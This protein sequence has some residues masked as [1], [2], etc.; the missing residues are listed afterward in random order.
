MVFGVD[1]HAVDIAVLRFGCHPC[2]DVEVAQVLV[3]QFDV[4]LASDQFAHLRLVAHRFGVD[5]VDVGDARALAHHVEIGKDVRIAGIVFVERLDVVEQNL[6]VPDDRTVEVTPC[7]DVV[8][9]AVGGCISRV[10]DELVG[11]VSRRCVVL[12]RGSVARISAVVELHVGFLHVAAVPCHAAPED[13]DVEARFAVLIHHEG[14]FQLVAVNRMREGRES[15][16]AVSR[17]GIDDRLSLVAVRIS[18]DGITAVGH[19]EGVD[20]FLRRAVGAVGTG[21]RRT[22]CRGDA[23]VIGVDQISENPF[24]DAVDRTDLRVEVVHARI[25]IRSV[26]SDETV[27]AHVDHVFGGLCGRLPFL[28]VVDRGEERV[29]VL[30]D[31]ALVEV[32]AVE[33]FAGRIEKHPRADCQCGALGS[34]TV[35]GR[36]SRP[37]IRQALAGLPQFIRHVV[38]ALLPRVAF[39]FVQ[40]L[41]REVDRIVADEEN[42]PVGGHQQRIVVG[43]QEAGFIVVIALVNF[44]HF[45]TFEDVLHEVVGLADTLV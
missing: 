3:A 7:S 40:P 44:R 31:H 8:F 43:A 39:A 16:L 9:I 2:A 23:P 24:G 17:F 11:Q 18:R 10:V 33:E 20:Q 25:G 28:L 5:F 37:Y 19:G 6:G 27:D 34:A 15:R 22:R 29:A 26:G 4:P 32:V 1:V 38:D 12:L 41:L 36:L 42:G 21:T 45:G 14:V 30:V 35:V 13:V